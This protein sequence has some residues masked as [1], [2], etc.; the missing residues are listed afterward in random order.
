[1]GRALI[2]VPTPAP[3]AGAAVAVA[4]VDALTT[5]VTIGPDISRNARFG[6]TGFPSTTWCPAVWTS[7]SRTGGEDSGEEALPHASPCAK[8]R[9]SMTT[10]AIT[11]HKS[12]Q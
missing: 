7:W 1:M 5:A 2:T 3:G 6:L 9:V 10:V 12:A 4:H 8:Y 11:M